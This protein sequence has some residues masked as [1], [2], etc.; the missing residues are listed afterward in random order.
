MGLP[1][2]PG[3]E[4]FV[5]FIVEVGDAIMFETIVKRRE[6]LLGR[7][8]DPE[9]VTVIARRSRGSAF[10][11]GSVRK[12]SVD[13]EDEIGNVAAAGRARRGRTEQ[14]RRR[15]RDRVACF[16]FVCLVRL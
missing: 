7:D 11:A 10:R 9:R 13:A 4:F 14:G 8:V 6:L 15:G 2:D 5:L 1:V 12:S 16:N 3:S